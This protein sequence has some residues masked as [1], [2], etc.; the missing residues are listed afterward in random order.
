MKDIV[1]LIEEN[2]YR[3][4]GKEAVHAG[5]RIYSYG[6]L[7]IYSSRVYENLRQRGIGPEKIVMVDVPDVMDQIIACIG[8]LRA[9]AA[10]LLI[11]HGQDAS[12]TGFMYEEN[13][14][15]MLL[16]DISLRQMLSERGTDGY[17]EVDAHTAAYVQYTSGSTRRPKGVLMERGAMSLCSMSFYEKGIVK[18]EPDERVAL[19]SPLTFAAG[20][21]VMNV[22]LT[23]GMTLFAVP[24]KVLT[25]PAALMG[26]FEK[27]R[28]TACFMTPSYYQLLDGFPPEMRAVILGGERI[29]KIKRG[30]FDLYN[31]Y[32]QSESGFIIAMHRLM[33]EDEKAF[34]GNSTLERIELCLL[35]EDG[36]P[37]KEG[38]SGEI[39]YS[40]PY[41]RRY[42]GSSKETDELMKNRVV[43]SGD[44]GIKGQDG[45][46][47][48]TGRKSEMFKIHGLW[49]NLPEIV[50]AVAGIFDIGD[51]YVRCITDNTK[52]F[53]CVYYTGDTEISTEDARER[54]S[55]R[56]PAY[57]L[58]THFFHMDELVTNKNGKVDIRSLPLPSPEENQDTDTTL[59]DETQS[60]IARIVGE[61]MEAQGQ[62]GRDVN[63]ISLGMSS[64]SAI[65]LIGLL[66]EKY[67]VRLNLMDIMKHPDIAHIS[68][69]I[70]MYRKETE[71]DCKDEPKSGRQY[72]PLSKSQLGILA[73]CEANKGSIQ[74]NIPAYM[75][76][77]PDRIEEEALVL[78]VKK[79]LT[80]HTAIK[81]RIYKKRDVPAV[82]HIPECEIYQKVEKEDPEITV[83]TLSER[84][85]DKQRERD[86]FQSRVM[87][88]TIFGER[89]YRI[90]IYRAPDKLYLF[91]DI[92]HIIADGFSLK[93]LSDDISQIL[94]GKE[95]R[96]EEVTFSEYLS[97]ER[98]DFTAGN[99]GKYTDELM[100]A[101]KSF[102]YP[103]YT[104]ALSYFAHQTKEI[105]LLTPKAGI[106]EY[107][108]KKGFTESSYCHSALLLTLFLLTGTKPFIATTSNG[109]TKKPGELMRTFGL[110]AKS[111][112]VVWKCGER[113]IAEKV[114]TQDYIGSIQ[115]QIMD[116]CSR[117][118]IIY[119]DLKCR[120]DLLFTYQGELAFMYVDKYE[121]V[122]LQLDTPKFPIHIQIRPRETDYDISLCYDISRFSRKDMELLYD[123]YI[124]VLDTLLLSEHISEV[125][126]TGDDIAGYL[127]DK[128]GKAVVFESGTTWLSEFKK[129]VAKRKDHP[130]VEAENG[131]YTYGELD[132]LSDQVA[133]SLAKMGVKRN[134][135]VAVRMPR[136]KEFSA[137]IVGIHKCCAAYVPV[138]ME[139]PEGRV[140]H[141]LRDSGARL[142]ITEEVAK[143][144][145]QKKESLA[146]GKKEPCP[147]DYAY[148]IYTSGSTGLP[149]GVMIQHSALY[150]YL[151]YVQLE[152][153]IR[154]ESR[155]SCY[156]SFSF[157]ISVEGLFTPLIAGGTVCIV[158]SKV[159]KDVRAL[160][161]YLRD[162]GVTGGCFPTQM[163]QMLGK[164]E[165][166]LMDYITLIG[167]KMSVIPGNKGRVFNAYGPTEATVVVSYHEIEKDRQY[168]DIPIGKAMYNTALYITDPFGNLLPDGAI[169]EL[170]IAGAQLAKGYHNHAEKTERAFCN[171]RQSPD[172]RVY[173][174]GDL[175]RY[176][177]EGELFCLG[178]LDRQMKRRGFRIE[179][180]EIEQAALKAPDVKEAVIRMQNDRMILYYTLQKNDGMSEDK[181]KEML[182]R[183]L[184][185]Y[186]MPDGYME[187]DSMPLT[188]N[189]KLDVTGLPEYHFKTDRYVKPSNQ[190][191]EMVCRM[192]GELLHVEKVGIYD[193]F[194][195]LGGNS[196]D[197]M[198]LSIKLGDIFELSDIYSGRTPAGMIEVSGIKKKF[199]SLPKRNMYPLTEE[200]KKFFFVE[201]MGARP[202][203]SYGNV[204]MLFRLPED[205]DMERLCG[206]LRRI[207]DNHPYLKVRFRK[208]P[209]LYSDPNEW[210]VAE[211]NDSIPAEVHLYHTE[212]DKGS[213]IRPYNLL[214]NENLYR[215]WL[216]E[217]EAGDKYIFLD[218]HHILYDGE[219]LMIMIQELST[220][221]EG[222]DI[223][224]EAVTGYDAAL[225]EKNR[226]DKLRDEV[227]ALYHAL[228]KDSSRTLNDWI[229][230]R[231][232]TLKRMRRIKS[233][234]E[235]KGLATI[236][237]SRIISVTK[238]RMSIQQVRDRCK[239]LHITENMFF[240]AA[241]ACMLGECNGRSQ[242]LY[243]TVIRN[244]DYAA[245]EHTVAMMC[246]TVPIYLE[247]TEESL[248]SE[249]FLGAL[250]RVIADAS[251][252]S[253]LSYDEICNSNN[254]IIPRITLIYRERPADEEI[255]PG[256][257]QI[258]LNN[259]E[260]IDTLM[261]KIYFNRKDE[262]FMKFDTSLDF[263]VEEIGTMAARLDELL[264]KV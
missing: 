79:V 174:T 91:F 2:C 121:A 8:I 223:L 94:L 172:I 142:L 169:G 103:Y 19:M 90:E 108:R 200:Q 7:W 236:M 78:A 86:F 89:L 56:L 151:K 256:C 134:D 191:E 224:P 201:E 133:N 165:K 233:F 67:R 18:T 59:Y 55:S 199:G 110:F 127:R 136:R 206:M 54:L 264:S 123:S 230:D 63:L 238:S 252:G 176:T 82:E 173:H 182:G 143:E 66:E 186:M 168:R 93:I 9:G 23:G 45:K 96:R 146:G 109:R 138:D 41:L 196:L 210:Y 100:E 32:G 162:Q 181:I 218:F 258:D 101:V 37:V 44:I 12:L 144:I 87:P 118:D 235:S 75:A 61:V 43:H 119:S 209:D 216:Y 263:S 129:Q 30:N 35:D 76:F 107:C 34:V 20:L 88:Y 58:P 261:V 53:I 5:S 212:P 33:S 117:R 198:Q 83:E 72:L 115:D 50:E 102:Q 13:D 26:Y 197:A 71:G 149:K 255:I 98:M 214:G 62:I 139:Y 70:M 221:M 125:S 193:D 237:G 184:P 164:N 247:V 177:Y 16:D 137:V 239:K 95:P 249:S 126:L 229:N 128:K 80:L 42:T 51:I 163:G 69:L 226:K 111:V 152:V 1:A 47:Y 81:T 187:L 245:L 257:K 246:R 65:R 171:L 219:S 85:L 154:S 130:A 248:S 156:A 145:L 6:E 39:C 113:E 135:F 124:R 159:R 57:M 27:N 244:R 203:V 97:Q 243:A 189:G 49:I 180:G 253:V 202:E 132:A 225:E 131:T 192:I 211:R 185:D 60:D 104:S 38:E 92:H 190:M 84:F 242:A 21:I 22:V 25:S 250:R 220:L 106:P 183:E 240:H 17:V 175:A 217:T 15:S 259:L 153:G 105:R 150:N 64:L 222:G 122:D 167:E 99:D 260:T 179:P 178:R 114:R 254:I 29:T 215:V 194:F 3:F 158:P 205:T 46:L 10:F 251:K 231:S 241:F 40:N 116:T 147:E 213:L 188:P 161:T 195:E 140:E 262:L 228:L 148:M 141:I 52:V 227:I 73:E 160:E 234:D 166:L 36:R 155:I 28:I 68:W 204:P 232:D 14:C 11:D 207:I 48:I 157:D 31:M 208:N 120:T 112:P 4:S 77:P 74:Y 170:C 24:P